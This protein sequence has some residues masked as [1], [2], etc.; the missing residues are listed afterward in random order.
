MTIEIA[1]NL[2]LKAK[3]KALELGR[4]L[5][6]IVEAALRSYLSNILTNKAEKGRE[7]KI[8]WITVAG[9]LPADFDIS[10]REKMHYRIPRFTKKRSTKLR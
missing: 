9:G 1:D 2:I 7:R 4:P 6:V 5:R 10:S 8:R 3:K